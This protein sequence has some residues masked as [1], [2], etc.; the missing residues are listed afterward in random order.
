M[1]KKPRLVFVWNYLSWGG[2]QVY[3]LAIMKLA[4]DDWN[5]IVHL[6]KGS[7]P[8]MIGYLT[9]LGIEY[10]LVD[11]HLNLDNVSG[12]GEKIGRQ[13]NRIKVEYQMFRD[14]LKY[15]VR[16]TVFQ[17]ETAPWQSIAFLSAMSARGAKVFLTL[18]NFLPEAP[19][20]RKSVWKARLRYVSYLRG[21]NFFTS[22][23]DTKK[24]LRGLV[25]DRF[26]DRIR[27]TSTAVNP[28]QIDE[29]LAVPFDRSATLKRFGINAQDFIVLA[30]GQ[31]IDRKGRWVFLD[32]ARKIRESLS[33]VTFVWLT[34]QLPTA[35][36]EKKIESYGLGDKLRI[37][38]SP[39]V[40]RERVDVLSFFRIAD[41]FT[42]PSYV[43]GLPI[44]LLEAMALGRPSISTNV[45]AIPEAVKHL[46]TGILI[47]AGDADSL[48]EWILK[49]H[50]D[51]ELRAKLG[52][53]GREFVIKN[54]DERD[55]AATA[56]AQYTEALG[57]PTNV[58]QH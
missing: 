9:Q 2:A 6:P 19:G 56:I 8:E 1:N 15:D 23:V 57:R 49:L 51:P 7:S 32:A 17:I 50:D 24:R 38:H 53:A 22:N 31:F 43:E 42:L 16:D 21:I 4:K 18:H 3:F 48:A 55:A 39:T 33:D 45:Y 30:V 58:E 52:A 46:Q 26:W 35:D 10:K 44:A 28:P 25:N 54:F 14:L 40:G 20:W 11:R 37:V 29:A 41:V 36:E 12:L 27:V 47:E 5:I 34:P 13:M